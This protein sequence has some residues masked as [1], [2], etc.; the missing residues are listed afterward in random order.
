MNPIQIKF[1]IGNEIRRLTISTGTTFEEIKSK[2]YEFALNQNSKITKEELSSLSFK[3]QDIEDDWVSFSSN[4]EWKEALSNFKNVL[5]IK[6]HRNQNSQKV[7]KEKNCRFGNRRPQ[8]RFFSPFN[9]Q[10]CEQPKQEKC[11]NFFANLFGKMEKESCEKECDL[12]SF[13]SDENITK[14]KN[15]V[16]PYIGEEFTKVLE[17]IAQNVQQEIAKEQEKHQKEQETTKPSNPEKVE[18]KV[19]QA[20]EKVVEEICMD[21]ELEDKVEYPKVEETQSTEDNFDTSV[22]L[23]NQMGFSQ[24][25]VNR[26][27]LQKYNGDI[28]KVIFELLNK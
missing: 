20:K 6:V 16:Q 14:A 2:I 17:E 15:F 12:A 3:Y 10:P 19:E 22:Q 8:C 18:Q 28:Q 1:Y 13:L 11:E 9:F 26:F 27:L 24:D 5:K 25:S 7:N 21:K 23:L 4:E